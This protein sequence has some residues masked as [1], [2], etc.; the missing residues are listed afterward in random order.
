M[1]NDLDASRML[2]V[3]RCPTPDVATTPGNGAGSPGVPGAVG[4]AMD[5]SVGDGGYQAIHHHRQ[6]AIKIFAFGWN[7]DILAGLE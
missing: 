2:A 6:R 1:G 3:G 4:A 5:G 7:C